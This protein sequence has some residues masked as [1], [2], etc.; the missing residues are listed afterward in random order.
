MLAA[1]STTFRNCPGVSSISRKPRFLGQ[2]QAVCAASS[3]PTQ[4]QG[5]SDLPMSRCKSTRSGAERSEL[6][7]FSESTNLFLRDMQAGM[8]KPRGAA[9]RASWD[10]GIPLM[11][12]S[13]IGFHSVGEG[14]C[15]ARAHFLSKGAC[16]L[17]CLFTGFLIIN[18]AVKM[19]FW[20]PQGPPNWG[21]GS[22]AACDQGHRGLQLNHGRRDHTWKGLTSLPQVLGTNL[23]QECKLHSQDAHPPSCTNI[24]PELT[25]VPWSLPNAVH[26]LS[27][28]AALYP[29]SCRFHEA[30]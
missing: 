8:P 11:C 30:W 1:R 20:A 3:A 5:A 21:R 17:L 25:G 26:L 22:K 28:A 9:V 4:T 24:R 7:D 14:D 23:G 13:S 10:N 16:P 19:A 2:G 6:A 27:N 15:T 12:G 18:T 29:R